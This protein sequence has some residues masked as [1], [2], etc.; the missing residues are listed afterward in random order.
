MPSL[1]FKIS[2]DGSDVRLKHK[3]VK[4]QLISWFL[5]PD[6]EAVS[7]KVPEHTN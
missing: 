5:F 6:K 4:C 2:D 3:S 1:V 7:K